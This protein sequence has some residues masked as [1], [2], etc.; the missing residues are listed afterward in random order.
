MVPTAQ[1][2]ATSPMYETEEARSD[3]GITTAVQARY[4]GDDTVRSHNVDV[5]ANAGVVTLRGTVESDASR[6]QAQRLAEGVQGVTS[7]DNRLQVATAERPA[8]TTGT[9][10]ALRSAED[11]NR[12]DGGWL[13][14]KIQAQYYTNPGLRP[15][16]IDVTSSSDG[17]VTLRGE[18]DNAADRQQ[19]VTIARNTEGVTRVEDNLRVRGTDTAASA[20]D[21]SSATVTQPDGWITAKIQA[22]YFMDGDVKGHEIDVDTTNGVVTLTGAV[23][24]DSARRQ[25]EALARNTDGVRTVQNQLTTKPAAEPV[26]PLPEARETGRDAGAK[27]EDALITTKIQSKYFLNGDVKGH[28]INVDTRNGVVTLKGSV[29]NEAQKKEAEEIA[30]M[31]D[32]VTKVLNA[33]T[34]GVKR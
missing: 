21:T 14:T 17:V 29:E 33:L 34:I 24:S 7:V 32:G 10:P 30:R 1:S 12:V 27:I 19:A 2:P 31:T 20:T 5:T 8:A 4:Y 18:I 28:E 15:W 23:E 11:G 13:T 22:K 6:Q 25:A 9:G 26:P 3:S 16:N